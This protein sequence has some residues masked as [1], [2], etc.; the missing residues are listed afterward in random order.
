MAT[1]AT[2]ASS[3]NRQFAEPQDQ[4]LFNWMKAL[5]VAKYGETEDVVAYLEEFMD[6]HDDGEIDSGMN[7]DYEMYAAMSLEAIE[8][9]YLLYTESR[10][11]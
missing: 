6:D 8:Q 10:G 7:L 4:R 2:V 5:L 11:K 3:L 9:D 1:D